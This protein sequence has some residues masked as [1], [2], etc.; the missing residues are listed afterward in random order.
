MEA[1]L[2]PSRVPLFVDFALMYALRGGRDLRFR[3]ARPR[4][5]GCCHRR[6]ARRVPHQAGFVGDRAFRQGRRCGARISRLS[7]DGGGLTRRRGASARKLHPDIRQRADQCDAGDCPLNRVAYG[8]GRFR[9]GLRAS[10]RLR[11]FALNDDELVLLL[12]GGSSSATASSGTSYFRPF[13]S[14]NY[15]RHLHW[16]SVFKHL[17]DTTPIL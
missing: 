6:P 2:L 17:F 11:F 10:A 12:M 13:R 9:N 5:N 14:F 16:S 1:R 15:D 8:A 4:C 7:L 3:V